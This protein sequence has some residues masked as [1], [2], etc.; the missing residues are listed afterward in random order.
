MRIMKNYKKEERSELKK[1]ISP[2]MI[3]FLL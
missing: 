3:L 1:E 2:P